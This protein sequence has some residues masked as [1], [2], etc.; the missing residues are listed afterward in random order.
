MKHFVSNSADKLV[1]MCFYWSSSMIWGKSIRTLL[2]SG[3][4]RQD[5]PAPAA[6]VRTSLAPL[7]SWSRSLPPVQ[8]SWPG[9][10][11]PGAG[12]LCIVLSSSDLR[13]GE[14]RFF[15]FPPQSSA[16]EQETSVCWEKKNPLNATERDSKRS[17]GVDISA[18]K[19]FLHQ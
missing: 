8:G 2:V 6:D 15:P 16:F 5:S 3:V 9:H 13:P 19:L 4:E 7:T 1:L 10:V 14:Q 11:T 12:A 18:T 17:R